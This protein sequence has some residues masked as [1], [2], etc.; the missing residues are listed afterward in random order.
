[1][2]VITKHHRVNSSDKIAH[3]SSVTRLPFLRRSALSG[4][5]GGPTPVLQVLVTSRHLVVGRVGEGGHQGELGST[6]Q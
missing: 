1:M 4:R 6:G 2:C 3:V 5:A